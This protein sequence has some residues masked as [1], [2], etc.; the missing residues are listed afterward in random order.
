[1]KELVE[2]LESVLERG[3]VVEPDGWPGEPS[4]RIRLASQKD[5]TEP[6]KQQTRGGW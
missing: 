4:Y 6:E 3:I 2:W 5:E 1:M